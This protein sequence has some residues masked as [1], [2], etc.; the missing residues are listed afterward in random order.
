MLNCQCYYVLNNSVWFQS[1][2][3]LQPLHNRFYWSRKHLTVQG[4]VLIY[5][6]ILILII[7]LIRIVGNSHKNVFLF[8]FTEI[9]TIVKGRI[10]WIINSIIESSNIISDF[11]TCYNVLSNFQ[12]IWDRSDMVA[13]L[14]NLCQRFLCYRE[15]YEKGND[16]FLICIFFKISC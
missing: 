4:H 5:P 3:L 14:S 2:V 12:E 15:M 1:P 10:E 7:Y 16:L 8:F 9:N 6:T 13:K 11:Y